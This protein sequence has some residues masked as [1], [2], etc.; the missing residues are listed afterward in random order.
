MNQKKTSP[1]KPPTK[2]LSGVFLLLFLLALLVPV[3]I[4]CAKAAYTTLGDLAGAIYWAIVIVGNGLVFSVAIFSRVA[5]STMAILLGMA[6]IPYQIQLMQRQASVQAEAARIVA[7]AYEVKLETGEFPEDLGSYTFEQA[8]TSPFIGFRSG[9]EVG[10][11]LVT[12]FVGTEDTSHW[13]SPK[14]GW[15]YHPD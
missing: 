1:E 15:R 13:Y 7:H 4:F 8:N 6:V 3:E 5:A 9:E 14:D 2:P 12:Y 10:G 11:F